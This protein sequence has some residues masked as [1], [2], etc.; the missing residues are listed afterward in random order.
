MT[1]VSNAC[2]LIEGPS[3]GPSKKYHSVPNSS[4]AIVFQYTIRNYLICA[5]RVN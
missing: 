5:I 4:M 3:H 1:K 2:K